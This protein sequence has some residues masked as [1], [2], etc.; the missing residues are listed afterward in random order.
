MIIEILVSFSVVLIV[1]ALGPKDFSTL[2]DMSKVVV[3]S[4][5]HVSVD[6]LSFAAW[7]PALLGGG[8]FVSYWVMY[9]FE[10]GGTLG[11]E[12]KDASRNAPKGILGAFAFAAICGF[13]FLFLLT[14]SL[15]HPEQSMINGTPAQDAISLHLPVWAVKLFLAVLAEGLIIASSTMFAG[16]T[17]HLFGMA[18]D[19]QIP[20]ASTW[21]RTNRAGSPWAAGL[22]LTVLALLPVFV[23]KAKAASMVGAATAAMYVAYFLVALVALWSVLRGWPR[24]RA[25]F[26]LGRW[27]LPVTIVAVLGAGFTAVNLLWARASTNPS[28]DQISGQETSSWMRHIPMGWYIVG[29]PILL[30]AAY[31]VPWRRK[32]L[33]AEREGRVEERTDQGKVAVS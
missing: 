7:V 1:F 33:A 20:F 16:A 12:T 13:A 31:Y 29:I 9:T 19:N 10:N 18:R 27:N 4:S 21:T 14:A 26:H 32:M 22:L 6:Q 24:T 28:F 30:G 25:V 15:T 3:S 2:T 5:G 17:R 11:E 23:F 8:I